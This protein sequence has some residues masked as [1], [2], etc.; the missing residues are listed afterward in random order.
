M[1]P[2]NEPQ[3]KEQ[4]KKSLKNKN[5]IYQVRLCCFGKFWKHKVSS[6][7]VHLYHIFVS[8][9]EK[10]HVVFPRFDF[11]Q[12]ILNISCQATFNR[13]S[14][15]I[16]LYHIFPRQI[17]KFHI[18]FPNFDFWPSILNIL[19]QAVFDRFSLCSPTTALTDRTPHD[20]RTVYSAVAGR[21]SLA[22]WVFK[23]TGRYKN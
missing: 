19:C 6:I 7:E 8:Q 23:F 14:F 18:V 22:M 21:K 4:R 17:Q 3:F 5:S 13:F 12:C 2:H 16:R 1:K 11:L 20:S 10:F 15:E 9:M